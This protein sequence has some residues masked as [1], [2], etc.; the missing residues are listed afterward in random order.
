MPT[1]PKT[2]RFDKRIIEAFEK[3]CAENAKDERSVL[4]DLIVEHL[5][6]EGAWQPKK[7]K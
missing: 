7:S 3:W 4:S 2:L 1:K 5:K 6:R